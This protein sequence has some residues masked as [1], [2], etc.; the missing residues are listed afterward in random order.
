MVYMPLNEGFSKIVA[1]REY[2]SGWIEAKALRNMDSKSVAAFV[3]EWIVRFGIPGMIIDDNGLENKK[4]TKI[5][6]DRYC[7]RNICVASYYPQSNAVI[8]R[9]HQQIVDGLA[10]LGPKWV[11]NLPFVG[12]ADRTTTRVSTGFTPHRLVFGQDCVL[13]VELY[14]SS[15]TIIEWRKVKTTAELLAARVR[16][17]ERREEDIEEAQENVRKSRLRNKAY[18]DKNRQERVRPSDVVPPLLELVIVSDIPCMS[19]PTF[20]HPCIGLSNNILRQPSCRISNS[21][22]DHSYHEADS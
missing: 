10:K 18:F 7:V 8:E 20:Q 6:I 14:A 12:W 22:Y 21:L 4:I 17:L 13:P 3:H 11:K 1:M 9:G 2:L 19:S 5:L 16:Q 15:W